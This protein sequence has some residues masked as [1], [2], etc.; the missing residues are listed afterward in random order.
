M[1]RLF[2]ASRGHHLHRAHQEIFTLLSV[3]LISTCRIRKTVLIVDSILIDGLSINPITQVKV[4]GLCRI[5]FSHIHLK[6]KPL[7]GL[8]ESIL[9]L[10]LLVLQSF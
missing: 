4:Y 3:L 8:V 5:R 10:G 6:R 1:L 9:R 7:S 2:P